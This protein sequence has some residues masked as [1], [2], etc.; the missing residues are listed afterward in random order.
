MSA[1]ASQKKRKRASANRASRSQADIAAASDVVD[2]DALRLL[3]VKLPSAAVMRALLF[4]DATPADDHAFAGANPEAVA[5][6]LM[7]D[8]KAHARAIHASVAAATGVDA[9]GGQAFAEVGSGDAGLLCIP[10]HSFRCGKLERRSTVVGDIC[11]VVE[12]VEAKQLGG[13]PSARAGE[14]GA[15]ASGG[16]GGGGRAG[17]DDDD[18]GDEPA[19]GWLLGGRIVFLVGARKHCLHWPAGTMQLAINADSIDRSKRRLGIVEGMAHKK[20]PPPAAGAVSDPLTSFSSS[21]RGC[22]LVSDASRGAG[23]G[24]SDDDDDGCSG[25]DGADNTDDVDNSGGSGGNS[26]AARR[27]E[28]VTLSHPVSVLLTCTLSYATRP[29]AIVESR[30]G[31]DRW[32]PFAPRPAAADGSRDP[33]SAAVA[34]LQQT[35]CVGIDVA[36]VPAAAFKSFVGILQSLLLL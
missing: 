19:S 33:V 29:Q 31:S 18:S 9:P 2:V 1:A 25:D 24:G 32:Q 34:T 7:A 5:T 16:A 20:A 36:Y 13:R 10:L 4:D 14:A 6:L 26:A 23:A 12:A 30:V 8:L 3:R 15:A 17:G 35:L 22:I 11:F 21:G 28:D 27:V